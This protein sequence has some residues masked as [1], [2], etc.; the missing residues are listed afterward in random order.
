MREEFAEHVGE[1]RASHCETRTELKRHAEQERKIAALVFGRNGDA[2]ILE[3]LRIQE[4]YIEAQRKI[5]QILVVA[6]LMSASAIVWNAI[7][8]YISTKAE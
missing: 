7:T 2:G 8:F 3:R 4:R 6:F 1:N 5:M